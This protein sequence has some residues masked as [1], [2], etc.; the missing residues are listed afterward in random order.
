LRLMR[1][2]RAPLGRPAAAYGHLL[3]RHASEF[4]GPS[5]APPRSLL[6]L[7]SGCPACQRLIRELNELA[8][9]AA[10]ALAWT[11]G[12]IPEWNGLPPGVTV[13]QDGA[14][15][16]SRVGVG[17]TP[18][19]VGFNSEGFVDEAGPVTAL[20]GLRHAAQTAEPLRLAH[21]LAAR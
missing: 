16:A 15:V 2:E 18:F 19:F 4:L 14:A 3:G 11:R 1:L 13:L 9:P 6:L 5:E 7:S 20:D 12:E 21:K 8:S 10:I 17:V